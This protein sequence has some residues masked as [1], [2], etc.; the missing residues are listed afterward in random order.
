[1]CAL[2]LRVLI[3][4]SVLTSQPFGGAEAGQPPEPK[5]LA[6]IDALRL[7]KLDLEAQLLREKFERIRDRLEMLIR[8]LARR[9]GAEGMTLDLAR[10]RWVPV[11]RVQPQAP[12]V[13]GEE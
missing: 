2:F 4:L 11:P 8:E 12:D 7:E 1:M 10:R 13:R 5:P 6:E 3:A 9:D